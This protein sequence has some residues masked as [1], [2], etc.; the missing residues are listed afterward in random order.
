MKTRGSKRQDE[1]KLYYNHVVS[2]TCDMKTMAALDILVERI[3]ARDERP[4]TASA[5][6]REAIAFMEKHTRKESE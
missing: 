1:K 6:I 2:F 5:A 4:S 3:A